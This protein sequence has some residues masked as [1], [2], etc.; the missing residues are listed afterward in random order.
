MGKLIDLTGQRFGRLVVISRAEKSSDGHTHWVCRC[1]CGQDTV[2]SSANLRSRRQVSC[3]CLRNEKSFSR[4]FI[5]NSNHRSSRNKRLYKI[6][7]GMKNRC[8]RKNHSAYPWYGGRGINICDEWKTYEVFEQW[9]LSSGYL[10]TL[11]IDRI[12]TNEGYTPDNCRWISM[13]EQAYNRRD[14]HRLTFNGECLTITEW[15]ER[16]GCTPTCLYYRLNAGWP[17]EEILTIPP[18]RAKRHK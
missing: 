15:A 9:A 3:G 6:W 13:R 2:V 14:N 8:E 12:D 17:I 16:L 18:N 4:I 10:P 11:T 7:L 5:Y 1:D